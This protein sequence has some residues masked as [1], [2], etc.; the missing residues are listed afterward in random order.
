[1][2]SATCWWESPLKFEVWTNRVDICRWEL[3]GES[4]LDISEKVTN[5]GFLTNT[6]P[7]IIR[8]NQ[9]CTDEHMHRRVIP[10]ARSLLWV[11]M[12]RVQVLCTWWQELGQ[13]NLPIGARL[14][15]AHLVPA[16]I[17]SNAA[18]YILAPFPRRR[19]SW[20]HRATSTAEEIAP[21]RRG[22][23][24]DTGGHDW[25]GRSSCACSSVAKLGRSQVQASGGINTLQSS[26]SC[27][28]STT[29]G[30]PSG[31]ASIFRVKHIGRQTDYSDF[32]L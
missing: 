13:L 6:A 19:A 32:W 27:L 29:Q 16:N 31:Q 18:V 25:G 14:S 3:H 26:A 15:K 21:T 9:P 1:M 7:T 11:C 8:L 24:E 28:Q 23:G 4:A 17:Y 10:L 22:S 2:L 30:I 5:N 12:F 20:R